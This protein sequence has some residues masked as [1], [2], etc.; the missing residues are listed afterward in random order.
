[1]KKFITSMALQAGRFDAYTYEAVGNAK[2][3]MATPVHFPILTAIHGYA[4]PGEEIRVFVVTSQTPPQVKNQ[5]ILE[6]ELGA[7]CQAKDI[8]CPKGLELV[9]IPDDQQ[10]DAHLETFQTL[11]DRM[12]DQDEL[13]ACTTYGTKPQAQAVLMALQYG[14][15]VKQNTSITC[16]V[17]GEIARKQRDK[18]SWSQGKVY[19]VT[20][21][22]QMDEIVRVL[23][24]QKVADP[25]A[26]IGHILNL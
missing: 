15:R 16:I 7:L 4:Q 19:D 5:A 24:E 1:M 23:A 9:V 20:A 13:F 25:K 8:R 26:V 2:L 10:V 18:D 12:E 22:T 3:Q 6:Q 21:L 17:Y 14:Y 11:I